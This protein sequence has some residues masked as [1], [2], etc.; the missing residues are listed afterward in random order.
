MQLKEADISDGFLT[1]QMNKSQGFAK[2]AFVLLP[3]PSC[4]CPLALVRSPLFR[5]F[6]TFSG[7]PSRPSSAELLPRGY[8]WAREAAWGMKQSSHD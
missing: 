5:R 2:L 3:L 8:R 1:G 7:H 6:S 4:P